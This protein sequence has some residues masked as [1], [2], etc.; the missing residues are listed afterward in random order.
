[1]WQNWNYNSANRKITNTT[2]SINILRVLWNSK[3]KIWILTLTD[4]GSNTSAIRY[5][6]E[7]KEFFWTG[8]RLLR[9]QFIRY[10]PGFTH[11]WRVKER[12][13]DLGYYD[14]EESDINLPVPSD[15]QLFLNLTFIILFC[16]IFDRI[17]LSKSVF[18]YFIPY[19]VI[20]MNTL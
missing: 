19:F 2:L 8:K 13:S 20:S 16:V 15:F 14:P 6:E 4:S 11:E 3:I 9:G 10:M 7:T 12:H 18:L 17:C 5:S 1:M